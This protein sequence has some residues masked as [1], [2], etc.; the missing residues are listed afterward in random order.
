MIKNLNL[1][2]LRKENKSARSLRDRFTFLGELLNSYFENNVSTCTITCWTFRFFRNWENFNN[3]LKE[4]SYL[5]DH[6]TRHNVT[7]LPF[8]IMKFTIKLN[9]E[10]RKNQQLLNLPGNFLKIWNQNQISFSII[11][12]RHASKVIPVLYQNFAWKM[13]DYQLF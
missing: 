1:K 12:C 13:L 8:A 2:I 7:L 4:I 3:W 6:R 9:L 10:N 11:I 5:H